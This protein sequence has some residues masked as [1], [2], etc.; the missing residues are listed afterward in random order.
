M[1]KAAL[2]IRR[3]N[4]K[5]D[6]R[7]ENFNKSSNKIVK[8]SSYATGMSTRYFTREF[9]FPLEYVYFPLSFIPL[10]IFSYAFP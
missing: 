3:Y 2:D 4:Y 8:E 9:L 7:N 6:K 1:E 5:D 10:T